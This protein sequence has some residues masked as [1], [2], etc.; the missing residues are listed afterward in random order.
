M[1]GLKQ[2]R[3]KTIHD[4]HDHGPCRGADG[5]DADP[6]QAGKNLR[7]AF[8]LNLGFTLLEIVG[9]LATNS[10]A[11]LSDALHDL[12]DAFSLGIAWYLQK[13]SAQDPDATFTYGYRRFSNLG[14]LITGLLLLAGLGFVAWQAVLRLQDPQPVKVPGMVA[15]AVVGIAFNGFA[16]WRLHGGHSMNEKLVSWH[17]LEDTL[18]WVAV[19]VGSLLML[20]WDLPII[21]PLLSLLIA[22]FILWNVFKNLRK[23]LLVF[24]QSSPAEFDLEAFQQQLDAIPGVI[25][26]HHTHTWTLDGQRHVFSTHLVLDPASTREEIVA[27]KR[28]VYELLQDQT[29]VHITIEAEL[30]GEQCLAP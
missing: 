9:G 30:E 26:N 28:Q 22:L 6:A 29:F 4:H 21:D 3:R 17:L 1:R 18:G 23:V 13:K 19:L 16:A 25:E 11:I 10:I 2:P 15:L 7:L 8:L 20:V 12:G 14:A 5:L 27:I 24:L